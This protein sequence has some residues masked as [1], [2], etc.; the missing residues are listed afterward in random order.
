MLKI[1]PEIIDQGPRLPEAVS[2]PRFRMSVASS[3]Q[4]TGCFLVQ[5][6]CYK[7]FGQRRGS[8]KMRVLQEKCH[9]ELPIYSWSHGLILAATCCRRRCQQMTLRSCYVWRGSQ[10]GWT[11]NCTQCMITFAVANALSCRWA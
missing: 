3:L 7:T 11:L 5:A 1:R 10:T 6:S 4:Y 2:F 8:S 9:V